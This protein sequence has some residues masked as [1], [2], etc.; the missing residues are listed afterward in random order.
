[1]NPTEALFADYVLSNSYFL[2]KSNLLILHLAKSAGTT[3][4]FEFF[5]MEG[6][7]PELICE[8]TA[9]P[10]AAWEQGVWSG[11]HLL[12][13]CFENLNDDQKQLC[14]HGREIRRIVFVR[15]PVERLWS[16]W[17]SKI[18]VGEPAFAG[19]R[20][21]IHG[22]FDR[23]EISKSTSSRRLAEY[24]DEFVNFLSSSPAL[25]QDPHFLPQA[26]QLGSRP[27]DTEV[28]DILDL[29]PIMSSY[30]KSSLFSPSRGRN[31]T[32]Q[33]LPGPLMIDS[34]A[35]RI[36]DLYQDDYCEF[37]YLWPDYQERIKELS[38]FPEY[39]VAEE[40]VSRVRAARRLYRNIDRSD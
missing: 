19:W 6:L 25:L 28:F 39:P 35:R 14:L 31:K 9:H 38:S 2:Q 3:L 4:L 15:E 32:R 24:F 20:D 17:V 29:Q 13:G 34:T 7:D 37:G 18:V 16:A 12:R 11:R 27:T 1:M 33:L 22:D 10:E 36:W 5:R 26:I 40:L 30:I 21:E 8:R 23:V